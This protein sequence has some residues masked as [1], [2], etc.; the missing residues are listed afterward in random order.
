ML[1]VLGASERTLGSATSGEPARGTVRQ[2]AGQKGKLR[3]QMGRPSGLWST[4]EP[5]ACAE[6]E[7][8]LR[9]VS[10][11]LSGVQNLPEQTRSLQQVSC[12]D[13]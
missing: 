13:L 12:S 8:I 3:Q 5:R 11:P 9:R 10:K 2:S 4:W 1:W 7:H 6:G